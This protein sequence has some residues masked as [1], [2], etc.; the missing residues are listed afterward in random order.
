MSEGFGVWCGVVWCGVVLL[1]CVVLCCCVVV[2][3]AVLYLSSCTVL[4]E[5]GL[6]C[7]CTGLNG[8]G[9]HRL[10]LERA[11]DLISQATSV[12]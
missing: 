5:E 9:V 11:V 4:Y 3:L 2:L 6:Y 1:C 10:P 8:T 7:Y 12:V